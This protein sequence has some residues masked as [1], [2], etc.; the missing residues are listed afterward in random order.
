[1]VFWCLRFPP[2]KER[3]QVDLRGHSSKVEFFRSFLEEIKDT[4]N[5]FEIIWPL[6]SNWMI[7]MYVQHD[8]VY[9]SIYLFIKKKLK[10]LFNVRIIVERLNFGWSWCGW[11][12]FMNSWRYV[13]FKNE[14]SMRNNKWPCQP[15]VDWKQLIRCCFD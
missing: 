4:K 10:S 6:R 8:V 15:A 2:K 5:H 12:N 9:L 3:K 14:L 1:M 11:I 13:F 7:K